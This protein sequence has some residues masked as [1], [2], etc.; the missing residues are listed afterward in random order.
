M[1]EPMTFETPDPSQAVTPLR[2][3]AAVVL[4]TETT[5]LD[6]AS[7]R[8]VQIGAVRFSAGG[9]EPDAV[10]ESLVDPGVPIPA[11]S[12]R[13]HGI[14]EE[15]VAGAPDFPSVIRRLAA[16]TGRR[17]VLGYSIGFDLAVLQAEHARANLHWAPPRSL[18]VAHLA[19]LVAPRLPSLA[20]DPVA[21]WLGLEVTGRHQALGD[22]ALTAAVYLALLP[23]L[24]AKG[25][26][27]LA[28]AER[29]CLALTG[30]AEEEAR[31]GWHEV[32]TPAR[33]AAPAPGARPAVDSFP[34]RHR[35]REIMHGPPAMAANAMTLETA[36]GL[37]M[38][39]RI[40]SVFVPPATP[41]GPYGIL[42]ERDLLRAIDQ[43]GAEALGQPV[44]AHARRPLVTVADEELV[45]RAISR[46]SALGFRH[47]GVTD[48]AGA[49]VG[50]L[51]ARDLLKQRAREDITLGAEIGEAE[52]AA[53][54][55]T[56]WAGLAAVAR[57]LA[58]DEVDARDIAGIISAELQALT[59]RAAEIAEAE[60]QATGQGG[61]PV[62]YAL[63]VLGSGGRG[64]S[65][66][67]MDQ[68][69]AIVFEAGAPGG[70]ADQWFEALGQRIARILD[71]AGV[72]LCQGGIM[73]RNAAWRMALDDWRRTVDRWIRITRP[74]NILNAD[75]FFDALPV[76]GTPTLGESLRLEAI[77][78]AAGARPFLQALAMKAAEV[79]AP[80]GWFG[81]F[82]LAD[83]RVDLKKGGLMALFSTARVL[84]LRHGLSE[85]STPARFAAA[86][87]HL[88]AAAARIDDLIEAH[89]L[90]LESILRQQLCDLER[91]IPPGNKVAPGE[92]GG[93]ERRN[94]R[95]A[96]ERIVSTADVLDVPRL[97]R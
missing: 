67:A 8:I 74:E 2:S 85:R 79:E 72:A 46:M 51:S 19:A 68:D 22:A 30:R 43:G 60:M 13:I 7:D 33:L 11:A 12:T 95:W 53:E 57:S 50:A 29:A 5:G 21:A 76:H 54:L 61:P 87:P 23:K 93:L 71:D 69:N 24:Q 10:F 25:I 27:S 42:T 73:A 16:F 66:L 17:L 58:E 4:D 18:D 63:L 39:E 96:L 15:A 86:R 45:Y 92:L 56:V 49:L 14:D 40:S 88:G 91:G 38:R 32:V 31:G 89:R 37:M 70:A 84:A 65:L 48:A 90:I 9:I 41:G 52:S 78:A 82:R 26:R 3:I 47:L 59:R 62:A 83:G 1:V 77:A 44:G 75:I 81:R 6:A 64:E 55:G 28:E 34:Y 36:L 80:L 94:L 97:G 35:V 20:L